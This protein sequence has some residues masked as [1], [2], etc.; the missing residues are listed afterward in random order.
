MA[1]KQRAGADERVRPSRA[2]AMK[3]FGKNKGKAAKYDFYIQIHS[4]SPWPAQ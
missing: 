1:R 4:L 2:G 3:L